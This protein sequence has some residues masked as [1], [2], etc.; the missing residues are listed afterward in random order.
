[1]QTLVAVMPPTIPRVDEIGLDATVLA[2]A[3]G[4]SMV[5][6]LFFGM[7]PAV[8]AA[9]MDPLAGLTQA[10][11]GVLGSSRA[12]WRHGLVV[13]QLSLATTLLV[14]AALLLQS[15]V[16]LQHV[17]LGFEPSGVITARLM[18]PRATYPEAARTLTFYQTLLQSLERLPSVQAVG[19]MTSAPFAPGVR[20]GASVR[21]RAAAAVS[22]D[23]GTSA[24][25]QIVTADVFRALGVRVLAG[26]AFDAHDR[27]GAPL[28]AIISEGLARRLWSDG[29]AIGQVLELDG[30][31][32]EV[33]GV[34]EDLRGNDGSGRRGGG[35]EREPQ[36]AVYLSAWQFPQNAVALVARAERDL[37]PILPAIRAAI[38]EI[39]PA[40]P[41]QDMRP[42]EDWIAESAAQPRLTT[43]LAGAFALAALLLAAVG[44]YGVVS[45][46]VGQRTQEIGVRMAMGAARTSVVGLVLR[47]GMTWAGGGIAVGLVVA[48]AVSRGIAS[49]LFDVS[50]R[51]PFTFVAAGLGLSAVALAAS[52]LPA[53]RATRIDPLV[54]LRTE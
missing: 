8:R 43:T 10:G 37:S 6:G 18:L 42:L 9:R 25:E 49:L 16:R 39:D 32:H 29:R 54:A 24:V 2:F 19:L 11:R 50:A 41:L 38:R 33:I 13:A 35:L 23:A 7:V 5:C 45:Y 47:E 3:L 53:I 31:A 36:A 1:M 30:R 26:R 52:A 27:L 22:P 20:R 15:F 40:Q 51:D 48:W 44:I 12:A 46:A 21:D 17:P 14:V 4:V 34:V 28:V